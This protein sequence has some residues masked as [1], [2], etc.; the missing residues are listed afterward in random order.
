[1]ATAVCTCTCATCGKAFEVR[2]NGMNRRDADSRA[3]WASIHYDECKECRAARMARQREEE[4]AKAARD[5]EAAGLP[6]LT[7]SEKQAAWATTIRQKFLDSVQSDIAYFRAQGQS[8]EAALDHAQS[9]AA[10][11]AA[12]KT[13]AAWWIDNRDNVAACRDAGSTIVN[14]FARL[15]ADYE[16]YSARDSRPA[17]EGEGSAVEGAMEEMTAVPENRA[18]DGE[19]EI[20]VTDAKIT[21]RYRRDD[22]FRAVVKLLGYTW[23][24]DARVWEKKITAATGA[25]QERAA[26]LGSKLL[27]AGFAI[28]IAD[29][30]T[31]RAAIE[32]R[33]EPEHQRWIMLY[34]GGDY[35]GWLSVKLPK[36]EDLYTAAKKI[37]GSKYS[38]P[39]IAVPINR[40]AEAEDFAATY[41]YR[42]TPAAQSAI[43]AYKAS[44]ITPAPAKYTQYNEHNPQDIL[45][46]GTE[47]LDDL[48]DT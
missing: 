17:A 45:N 44:L 35:K 30:D 5:A 18:H 38:K 46:S 16:T 48:L 3:E 26:E 1:M 32:G 24:G 29:E 10:W 9:F 39:N 31:R 41:D 27:N 23:D 6:D 20:T 15:K 8:E 12:T 42:I 19:A 7:G 13:K 28:R 36:G 2:V 11:L 4:N 25:P 33:Y 40:Y 47:V 43:E 37:P 34:T 14:A 22:D 21:V